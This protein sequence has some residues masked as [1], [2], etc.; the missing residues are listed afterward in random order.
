MACFV[1]IAADIPSAIVTLTGLPIVGR[2]ITLTCRDSH[3][4]HEPAYSWLMNGAI[5][6]GQMG[7]TFIR[8]LTMEDSGVYTC[9]ASSGSTNATSPGLELAV[10]E[11][12]PYLST[13]PF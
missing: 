9:V 8:N 1:L 7:N 11:T 5:V 3:V 6:T 12:M 10:G 13:V 4:G 2:V